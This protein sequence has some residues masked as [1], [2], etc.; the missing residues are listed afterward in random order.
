[1]ALNRG[2]AVALLVTGALI[3]A[4]A[5]TRP[6][7]PWST[8]QGRV[9]EAGDAT[10]R[11]G[12]VVVAEPLA[13]QVGLDVL[14]A[15]GNAMDAAVAVSF[16]LAVTYPVA[17]NLGGGGF[18][19]VRTADGTTAA[20]DFRETAPA[21]ATRDMY[22]DAAGELTDASVYGPRA[23]GV[24]GTVK[25]LWEAHRRFGS[26]R[27]ELLVQPSIELARAMHPDEAM[28][29]RL[30][31]TFETIDERPEDEQAW[32]EITKMY[33]GAALRPGRFIQ[34]FLASTLQRLA[35]EGPADF[36]EGQTA[37]LLL[38]A[39]G[40][41]GGLITRED[42]ASYEAIWRDPVVF[43]Y[44]GHTIIGM[45]PSSS[46]GATMAQIAHILEGWDLGAMGF[47]S[48]ERL[49]LTAEAFKR[50]YADRNTYLGDPDFVDNPVAELT[51]RS[52][53]QQRAAEIDPGW[54]TPSSAVS[55]GLGLPEYGGNTTHFSIVDRFGNAVA[56]TTTL[57]SAHGSLVTVPGAGFLLNSEM[58]DFAARPGTPNSYGLV[59]GEANAIA[60]GKRMLSSMSPSIVLDPEGDL[61]MV[62][63]T[64]G[65]SRIISVTFQSISNVVDHGMDVSTA[66]AAPRIHH[67]HL[68]DKLWY[69]AG[70]FDP[71]TTGAL[72]VMG[73]VLDARE[74]FCDVQAIVVRP[75]GLL[76]GSADPRGT[77]IALGF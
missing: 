65:G 16:A 13:A 71:V 8:P 22:L 14:K 35:D 12:M 76:T 19:V 42:L 29:E 15:G 46:G 39:M 38:H 75:N 6:V 32:Y 25:G 51:S 44:R 61:L 27:W 49:H 9:I 2:L 5:G 36:Y 26:R 70:G 1:M 72:S 54:A 17:G 73:H 21:A 20:L 66:V 40:R 57:N 28:R 60:G 30:A 77:G 47:D 64:P 37:A 24:P 11:Q 18:M 48:P 41:W 31:R 50:A 43:E 59:Q 63:G 55:P 23:A 34:P 74:P 10:G 52:Y 69:E 53:A 3:A 58:D 4:C 33:Y 67:Q 56:V 62:T 7:V 45:S 68:P